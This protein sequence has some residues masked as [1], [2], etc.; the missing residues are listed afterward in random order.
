M[1][2][3]AAS[4]LIGSLMFVWQGVGATARADDDSDLYHVVRIKVGAQKKAIQALV[5]QGY[6]LAGIND[7][8][9][10]VD[11]ITRQYSDTL[12]A[13]F[14]GLDVLSVK[15]FDRAF[16]PDEQYQ[17]P[18]EIASIVQ[19]YAALYPTLAHAET[20][21]KTRQRRP[22]WALKISENVNAHD[23]KRPV[24]LFNAMHHAREIMTPEV[25]ID[26]IDYLLTHYGSDAKVTHWLNN[27][28]IWI[29]PQVN[30]DGNNKVWTH[31]NMWRKNAFGGYGV[32]IN[33]NYPYAWNACGGSSGNRYDQTYRGPSAASEPETKALMKLVERIQPVFNIS[34]HSYSELVLYPYGCKDQ[35]PATRAVVEKIG[36]GM[37]SRIKKDSGHGTY[38]AGTPW[39]ILYAV[40][41]G[42]IDWMYDAFHVLAF[43]I[44][45]NSDDL[46]F[47]PKF[48]D[49]QPT[50]ESLRPAWSYLLDKLDGSAV[51]GMVTNHD[52]VAQP[53][54]TVTVADLGAPDTPAYTWKVKADGSYHVVLIPGQY[55]LTF[56][57]G[58]KTVVREVKVGGKRRQLDVVL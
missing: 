30:P 6:D 38:K 28:E 45:V 43:V 25:A 58:G 52:G 24:I 53:R 8:N 16:T 21:G 44:E 12:T 3:F 11:I 31:D 2:S 56:T 17:T 48:R 33:R 10:T 50:V 37:A 18:A 26:T 20:I 22:I 27:N 9:G 51:R 42:D 15:T 47:Q 23:P 4:F 49:R 35:Y 7:E 34:Y 46:G 32:D 29:V 19:H 40:D 14:L 5:D 41:G 13:P 57:L 36:H 39:E 54:A 55:R 1:R